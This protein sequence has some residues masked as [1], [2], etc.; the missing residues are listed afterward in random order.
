MAGAGTPDLSGRPLA[1]GVN[2]P[3]VAS[4]RALYRAWTA[5]FDRWFAI[6]GSVSMEARVGAPFFFETEFGGARQPHYGR[7]LRLEPDA[8][9]EMAWVSS[10]TLGLETVVTVRLLGEAE[11]TR[12]SL[13]H[14]G[15]PDEA[16]RQRHE[17]AWPHVLE[18][19][20][21]VLRTPRTKGA[22]PTGGAR[23]AERAPRR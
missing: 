23:R 9:V 13:T 22:G 7:F 12:L 18:H 1:V 2:R 19:L 4:P 20:E 10:A 3:M 8:L 15:F 17:D 5:E 16:S 6:P 14:A 11:G 21:E